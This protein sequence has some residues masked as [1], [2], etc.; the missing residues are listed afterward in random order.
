MKLNR[1]LILLFLGLLVVACGGSQTP[2]AEVNPFIGTAL[3][4]HTSPA[5]SVPFGLVQLGPD[6]VDGGVAG[7]H[8]KDSLILGFSHTH[9]SGTGQ[10]D[11]GDFLFVPIIGEVPQNGRFCCPAAS[12]LP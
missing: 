11:L 2:S 1:F 9:L 5:A 12:F 6:T 7:Y 8:D 10:G 4:G 3:D